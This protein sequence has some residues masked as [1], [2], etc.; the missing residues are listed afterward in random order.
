VALNPLLERQTFGA[1]NHLLV[2][3]LTAGSDSI[4]YDEFN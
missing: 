2:M 1:L 4:E 3:P